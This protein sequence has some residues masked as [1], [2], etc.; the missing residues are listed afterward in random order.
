MNIEKNRRTASVALSTILV[1]LLLLGTPLIMFSLTVV[2]VAADEEED[3]L[4]IYY[5]KNNNGVYEQGDRI[6]GEDKAASLTQCQGE[7]LII[8]VLVEW[9]IE[10][11]PPNSVTVQM[12]ELTSFGVTFNPTTF[13][14]SRSSPTQQYV[15]VTIP[16]LPLGTQHVVI[17]AENIGQNPSP[18]YASRVAGTEGHFYVNVI[19]CGGPP[20]TLTLSCSGPDALDPCTDTDDIG[21]RD[22]G[23]YVLSY[24]ITA[25]EDLTDVRVQGGITVKAKNI[26]IYCDGDE[27]WSSGSEQGWP[28][29]TVTVSDCAGGQLTI[30]TSKKNNVLTWTFTSMDAGESHTLTIEFDWTPTSS[31][32][33]SIAGEWSAVCTSSQGT[34]KTPYTPRVWVEV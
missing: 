18:P 25:N 15:T 26:K 21:P 1:L 6:S 9:E 33:H 30:N 11:R 13:T 10:G 8:T 24:T 32:F 12:I 5:D 14:L 31:G 34:T 27:V 22:T 28:S 7:S 29:G 3:P 4:H 17:K 20:Q 2:A 16:P 19:N 23:H